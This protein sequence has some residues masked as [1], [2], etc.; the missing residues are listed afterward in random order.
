M[1]FLLE[2]FVDEVRT[3]NGAILLKNCSLIV[4]I[5]LTLGYA[6]SPID[7]IPDIFGLLGVMDDAL[8]L[9]YGGISVASIFYNVLV[10]RNN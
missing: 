4:I 10:E 6:I 9:V 5:L 2:R 7:L 1:P 3:S 8:V